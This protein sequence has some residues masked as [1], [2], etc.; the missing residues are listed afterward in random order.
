VGGGL[1]GTLSVDVVA[2]GPHNLLR[3]RSR[4]AL[5]SATGSF[6]ADLTLRGLLP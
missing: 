1:E 4:T 2:T 3:L 6:T 5:T